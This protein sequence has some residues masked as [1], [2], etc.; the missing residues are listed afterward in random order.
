MT[1]YI[2][3][4]FDS[5]V[6]AADPYSALKQSVRVSDNSLRIQDWICDLSSFDQVMVIGAGKGVAAMA[7]AL[8][9]ILTDRIRNGIVIVKYGHTRPIQP[10]RIEQIEAGHPL[11]DLSGV[12]GTLEITELLRKADDK[13]L[14]LCLLTGG[15]S[16]LLVAPV[17]GITLS[18]RRPAGADG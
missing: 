18:K 6:R 2:L 12:T 15:G 14:I 1:P 10:S 16:S 11:P 3:D 7:Q 8:E 4:I 13:A 5:A 17:D 9:E